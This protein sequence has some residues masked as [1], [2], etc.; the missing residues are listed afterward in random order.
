M[1]TYGRLRYVVRSGKWE[2]SDI[3]PHVAIRLKS[4]F[5]RLA[6]TAT[7]PFLLGDTP[8]TCADLHWFAQR[9]PLEVTA[10]DSS[11]LEAGKAAFE[12]MRDSVERILLPDWQPCAFTGL[13]VRLRSLS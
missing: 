3:P 2:I 4:N 5:P 7:S 10:K 13:P 9:Y 8:D 1:I 12:N 11:R 6:K